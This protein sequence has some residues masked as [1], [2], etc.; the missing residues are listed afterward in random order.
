[1]AGKLDGS[2]I[3]SGSISST[4]LDNSL[5]T[6]I[7]QGGGPKIT[8]VQITDSSYDVIDDTAVSTSGGYIKITGTGFSIG[9]VVIV[10]SVNATS[11]S[12]VSN[13]VLNVQVPAQAAGTYTLYVVNTDGGTAVKVNGLTY[14]LEPV[15]VTA[16]SLPNATSE[17]PFS[18]Q[19]D[20]TGA[21]TYTLQAGSSL[22]PNTTLSSGGLLSGNVSVV[23]ETTYNFTIVATDAEAQDSP[24][25]FSLQVTTTLGAFTISPTV[26]GKSYWDLSIDGPL[27]LSTAGNYTI[28]PAVTFTAN[29][30][31]WGSGGQNG[32]SFNGGGGGY[33][34]GGVPLTSGTSYLLSVGSVTGGG[35][36]GGSGAGAGGGLT[37]IFAN[38]SFTQANALM[39]AGG[40]GGGSKYYNSTQTAGAG[41]GSSGQSSGGGGGTQV[42]G[43]AGGVGG[44]NAVSGSP[45]TA[46]A[47]GAGATGNAGYPGGGGGAGWYGGGGGHA[48]NSGDGIGP[49]GGGGSGYLGASIISGT[50]TTGSGT[51]PA[52]SGDA[53][54]GTAGS[55]NTAGK[56][57]V[58]L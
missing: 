16:S 6:T 24:R 7:S 34:T 32:G 40:G 29:V 38:A 43:G 2:A 30:K 45:G 10:G 18:I 37:G 8:Q 35:A 58:Y 36:G 15:W 56:I 13:T 48:R 26:D 5:N 28:V 25:A 44:G 39:I 9:A 27:S 50:T 1:M 33:S 23:S 14:S 46:L 22:P 11:T 31:M 19:L 12:F 54:R 47:G 3:V 52:N 4:Q 17:Q 57:Y 53:N 41:G 21:T 51:T 20:A 49:P 42:A 55:S